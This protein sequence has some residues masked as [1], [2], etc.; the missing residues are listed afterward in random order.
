LRRVAITG[1]GIVSCLGNTLAQVAA[2][3][4]EGRSGLTFAE[5]YARLGFRSQVA[6]IPLLSDLP[7]IERKW[8]RFMGDGAIYAYHAMR[9]AIVDAAVPDA[10]ISHARSGLI[11][12]S[13]VGST[14]NHVEAIDTLRAKGSGKVPPYMVPR[15]MGNT[16]S[17]CLATAFGIKGTSYSIASACATSA[18]SIGNA[19]ELIASGKQD[20]VFAGG[21]EEV[22][23]PNTL[24]FDAMGALSASYNATPERAS[25]PYDVA[26]DGFV[27][28]GGA[29]IL[30]LE[31]LDCALQRGARVPTGSTWS[32]RRRR[33]RPPRCDWRSRRGGRWTT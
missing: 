5:E 3:L 14:L 15:V 20:L 1:L 25:R 8:R 30:V 26:R 29:G 4:R 11:V 27:I 6:G 17:A 32:R 21:A 31:A 23:W 19:M 2:A 9:N 13:G 24:L 33:A 12:G 18:H 16:V 7:A 28:A 10:R 22:C